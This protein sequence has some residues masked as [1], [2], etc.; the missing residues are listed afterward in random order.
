MAMKFRFEVNATELPPTRTK[1]WGIAFRPD[2]G[3]PCDVKQV[4]VIGW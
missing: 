2:L 4:S 3:G 1:L